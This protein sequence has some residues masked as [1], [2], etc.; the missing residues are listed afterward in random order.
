MGNNPCKHTPSAPEITYPTFP[1]GA[2]LKLF[3]Q[4][5]LLRYTNYLSPEEIAALDFQL[6]DLN[7]HDLDY[8]PSPGQAPLRPRP[9]PAGARL[10]PPL[11]HTEHGGRGGRRADRDR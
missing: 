11:P 10:R 2:K 4:T 5:D 8:V 6:T 1:Q 7:L 3:K 9:P